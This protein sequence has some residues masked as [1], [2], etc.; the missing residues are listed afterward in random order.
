MTVTQW[1]VTTVLVCLCS[2]L[3]RGVIDVPVKLVAEHIKEV[4]SARIWDKLLVVSSTVC[5]EC[6]KINIHYRKLNT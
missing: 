4:H 2:W 3:G 1:F 6:S 5:I